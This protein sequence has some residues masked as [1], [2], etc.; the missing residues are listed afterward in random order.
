MHLKNKSHR[1]NG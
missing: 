1:A